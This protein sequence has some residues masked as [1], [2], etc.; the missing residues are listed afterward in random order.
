MV[1][2]ALCDDE[3][4]ELAQ[5]SELLEEYFR[6]RGRTGR[7]SSFSSGEA[8][9]AAAESGRFDLYLLDIILPGCNGIETGRR[10]RE[11]GDGSEI[12]YLTVSDE[13]AVE[14]YAVRAF[15]YLLKP[16]TAA[17][18]FP[19]LDEVLDQLSRRREA[20]TVMATS[21][22]QRRLPLDQLYYVERA[23]R[24]M[25]YHCADGVLES[26][27]FQ[28]PFRKKVEPLLEHPQFCLCGVS[29]LVNLEHVTGVDGAVALLDDGSVLELPRSA[30]PAFKLAWGEYWLGKG[31]R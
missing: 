17:A 7:V 31:R 19:V 20:Y 13:Y 27:T 3:P 18:L 29:Y 6:A 2:I 9:L 23:G 5:L 21:A 4:A 22:G 16:V 10:L 8:L 30:A 1:R 14:S 24:R 26:L 28:V 15:F 25:R 12:L 11:M